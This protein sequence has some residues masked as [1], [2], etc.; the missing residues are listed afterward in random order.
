MLRWRR[1]RW[2]IFLASL[3]VD[4]LIFYYADP[5]TPRSFMASGVA[6]LLIFLLFVEIALLFR[7]TQRI[8]RALVGEERVRYQV[9]RHLVA[10]I[11]NIARPVARLAIFWPIAIAL[12]SAWAIGWLAWAG[13]ANAGPENWRVV[14]QYACAGFLPLLI[15]TPFLL[16][17]MSEWR[18]HQYVV[19]VDK[20]LHKPSLLV[21][22]GVFSYNLETVSLDRTVTTQLEQS[23]WQ[24]MIAYGDL[25]L[26]ETAGGDDARKL[27]AVWRPRKLEREIRLA[28][29]NSRLGG[30]AD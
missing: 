13:L 28:I 20:V 30:S 2:L 7:A 24:S 3:G 21:H 6:S 26:R 17:F 10:L 29:R 5:F 18:S 16:E 15:A 23:F 27:E 1:L 9:G 25:E 19:I 8:R 4:A 14:A 11:G 12:A 22:H